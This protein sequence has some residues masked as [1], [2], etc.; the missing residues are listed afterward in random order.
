MKE[1]KILTIIA[2]GLGDCI[3]Y[4]YIF[5]AIKRKYP[6][7]HLTCVVWSHGYPNPYKNN[8]FID[9]LIEVKDH[10]RLTWNKQL[11]ANVTDKHFEVVYA[12]N[13]L[14]ELYYF[15]DTCS[16]DKFYAHYSYD[17]AYR[18][19][20]PPRLLKMIDDHKKEGFEYPF[21]DLPQFS[22]RYELYYSEEDVEKAREIMNSV[23]AAQKTFLIQLFSDD[24]ERT[25][26]MGT[27]F[28]LM[29]NLRAAGYNVLGVGRVPSLKEGNDK[30]EKFSEL[31]L[32]QSKHLFLDTDDKEQLGLYGLLALLKEVD[33]FITPLTSTIALA[34]CAM[35]PSIV[36]MSYRPSIQ[37]VILQ[38]CHYAPNIVQVYDD[39]SQVSYEKIIRAKQRFSLNPRWLFRYSNNSFPAESVQNRMMLDDFR[40]KHKLK[41]NPRPGED[42]Y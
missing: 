23:D 24:V 20:V 38:F 6:Q 17:E 16:F 29:E 12:I 18:K 10:R 4:S 42:N 40:E 3:F 36:V 25:V 37:N 15:L 8:P 7:S 33:Y 27:Q 31:Y 35:T 2:G 41:A 1:T 5:S 21:F 39:L 14:K 28:D 9:K 22:K 34:D 26:P 19:A 13:H 32:H 11:I 30:Y